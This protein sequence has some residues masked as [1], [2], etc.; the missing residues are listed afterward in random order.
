[1]N[2]V[3]KILIG[4]GIVI[5]LIWAFFF[6]SFDPLL[7]WGIIN[8]IQSCTGAK[9]EI[10]SLKTK[11]L[12]PMLEIKGL[13][14][15]SSSDEYKNSVE[16]AQ[17]KFEFEAMPLL[18]KKFIADEASLKGLRFGT[19]RK[20]SGKMPPGTNKLKK[21][22]KAAS[23]YVEKMKKET[24][25]YTLQRKEELKADF[26]I[27][28]D[29]LS[30]V[31]LAKQ[32]EEE[33]KKTYAD[34]SSSITEEKYKSQI[35]E[36]K[37]LYEAAKKESNFLKQA[38][39]YSDVAKKVKDIKA[40]F[41]ADKKK[42]ADALADA[43]LSMKKL[44]AAKKEDLKGLTAKMQLPSFDAEAIAKMIAGPAMADKVEIAFSLIEKGKQY[45]KTDGSENSLEDD[46]KA[47]AAVKA[48]KNEKDNSGLPSF[49]IK[50][51]ALS[52]E[53]GHSNPLSFDGTITDFT[54]EPGIWKRPA[55]AIVKGAQ[56]KKSLNFNGSLKAAKGK[57][58]TDSKLD[59]K[60]ADISSFKFGNEN[61]LLVAV[62]DSLGDLSA[63]LKTQGA[64]LDGKAN[65]KLSGTSFTP[66]SEKLTG[67]VKT[68]V[69]KTFKNLKSATVGVNIGGSYP[70]PSIGLTTDLASQLSK[71]LQSAAGDEVKK[72]T[73]KA[74][75]KLE[76]AVKPYAQK[77][78]G[79]SAA[80]EALVNNKLS[81]I[82]SFISKET[83]SMSK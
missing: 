83:S 46:E 73:A 45:I 36:A 30:S 23:D 9:A 47:E 65:L 2:L 21:L 58:I 49:L 5:V 14:A 57:I 43:K 60:G 75:A 44:D 74:Q 11:F 66:S 67:T 64:D 35:D 59:F 56:G 24:S 12:H 16:F 34:I 18:K 26:T 38:K 62:A 6:F 72:A 19:A 76:E 63:Q 82:Q 25:S 28:P 29:E 3:K 77:L 8:G 55:L 68:V 78:L 80:G 48:E 42:V 17:L 7:K 1:M 41:E 39:A 22:N 70:A 71:G 27:N 51:M 4:T 81:A 15:A 79:E 69:D 53:F 37:N 61:S 13:A 50:K 20:T 33:Y 54:T 40:G 10:A 32:L 31:K 52:G